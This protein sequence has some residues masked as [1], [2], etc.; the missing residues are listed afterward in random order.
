MSDRRLISSSEAKRFLFFRFLFTV[1]FVA[2][3]FCFFLAPASMFFVCFCFHCF[4]SYRYYALSY[5]LL[6][7]VFGAPERRAAAD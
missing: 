4:V 6:I 7:L 1:L 3:A 5:S 2:D